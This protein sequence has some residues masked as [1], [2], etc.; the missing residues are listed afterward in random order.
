M[1][2]EYNNSFKIIICHL[3]HLIDSGFWPII[4]ISSAFMAIVG[5][6]TWVRISL[7]NLSSVFNIEG[8]D[9]NSGF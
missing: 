1:I 5:L 4:A 6:V 2:L 9:Y 3:S 8:T 7:R